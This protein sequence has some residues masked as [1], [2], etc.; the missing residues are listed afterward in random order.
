[1]RRIF[2]LFTVLILILCGC[3]NKPT[4]VVTLPDPAD[5]II[6]VAT[7]P[8]TEPSFEELLSTRFD[9]SIEYIEGL[10]KEQNIEERERIECYAL[11]IYEFVMA[12]APEDEFDKSMELVHIEMDRVGEI[13]TTYYEE[14]LL[15]IQEEEEVAKWET[16]MDEYP[17]ATT[18]W[19]Y[20]TEAMGYNN[21][22]A[23]GIMG[24]MMAECGG[25][26][27]KL[28]YKAR[29]ASGHYGLCQWSTGFTKV[30]GADLQGQLSF[31]A[32][33]FPE[34]INRWGSICY[35]KGFTYDDFMA[36]EDAEEAAYAFCVIYERPGPGSYNQRRANAT[37]AL[38]Y[39][40]S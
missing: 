15:I 6:T 36:M 7:E 26:T 14:Y 33:S 13:H 38:E 30:Q 31:M 28:N 21:Y 39:F 9:P 4:T 12:E 24:N 5:V 18:V 29:N 1:M 35:K 10:S 25:Q 23:A 22:V 34:Q 19:K 11:S 20:L 32:E 2:A 8:P 3:S 27:L 17:I 16:R 37:K 40:T